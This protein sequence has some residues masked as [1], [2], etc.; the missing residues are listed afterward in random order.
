[1]T[2]IEYFMYRFAVCGSFFGALFL[3]LVDLFFDEPGKA[4]FWYC[5]S[6]IS[7]DAFIRISYGQEF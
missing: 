1:M 2:K 7:L 3:M 4:V 5:W 6:F